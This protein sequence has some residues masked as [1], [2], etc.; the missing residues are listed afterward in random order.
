MGIHIPIS[1]VGNR[2]YSY[3]MSYR[4]GND[5]DAENGLSVHF[6]WFD[7][8]GTF[9]ASYDSMNFDAFGDTDTTMDSFVIENTCYH[10]APPGYLKDRTLLAGLDVQPV[11]CVDSIN[12]GSSIT[13]S[14]SFLDQQNPPS[15]QITFDQEIKLACSSSTA[16]T[17]VITLSA[18][19]NN[20]VHVQ[21]TGNDG[22]VKLRMCSSSS[23]ASAYFHDDFPHSAVSY[24]SE[25][26]YGSF[27]SLITS[28]R[29]SSK[30]AFTYKSDY[31]D[32]Y[33]LFPK[34]SSSSEI[35]VECVFSECLVN[36]YLNNN[37]QCIQCP[38]GGTSVAGSTSL[39]DCT[40]C[41]GGTVLSHPRLSGCVA[42]ESYDQITS[43]T[44]WR[45]WA[46][47]YDTYSGWVWDVKELE[48]YDNLSCSGSPITG[49]NAIDSGNAGAGWSADN[50]FNGRG[51]TWG[52]R[53]DGNDIFY[54]GLRFGSTSKTV[55]CLK[56]YQTDTH[57]ALEV[58]VQ[59]FKNERWTNAWIASGLTSDLNTISLDYSSAPT[60]PT[61]TPPSSSCSDTSLRFNIVKNDGS[62]IW[63]NCSWVATKAGNRCSFDGVSTTCP[64]TCGTCDV[65]QDSSLRLKIPKNGRKIARNCLWVANKSTASRCAL[66]GVSLACRDTC[67]TC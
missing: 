6:S 41:P 28:K 9:G 44:G 1:V 52:G 35:R 55:R 19:T 46:P 65:C 29:C 8:G 40:E 14:V 59:V 38:N 66:D 54:I 37:G 45:I 33:I 20:L 30:D 2:L 53:S 36:Q 24:G 64:S 26:A 32:T 12:R 5:G 48:F 49:G 25:A 61:P 22:E 47:D 17:G 7:L 11:V 67:G 13:V 16:S 63:R 39:N 23:T 51:G 34:S 31:G 27:K 50:A 60:P 56:L 62:K 58:R 57:V 10:L 43:G 42:L 18:N 4:S 15:P 21:N 3:W